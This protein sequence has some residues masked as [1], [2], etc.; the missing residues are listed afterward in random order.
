MATAQTAEQQAASQNQARREEKEKSRQEMTDQLAKD[1]ADMEKRNLEKMEADT[2]LRPTP[3]VDEI[4][5]AIAG[6]SVDNKESDGSPLQNE[7]HHTLNPAQ[8]I[9]VGREMKSAEPV[10]SSADVANQNNPHGVGAAK[11]APVADDNK[12]TKK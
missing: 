9:E 1:R 6:H 3:T 5:Q 2:K 4:Q 12:S 7:R 8:Q 10:G 11:P